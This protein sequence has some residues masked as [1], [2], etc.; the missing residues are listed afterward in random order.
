LAEDLSKLEIELLRSIQGGKGI[1][2]AAKELKAPA[3]I[4]GEAVA[5][6]QVKGYLSEDGSVTP[7]GLNALGK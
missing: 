6:L 5:K 7:K 1:E 2:K 3:V 4:L